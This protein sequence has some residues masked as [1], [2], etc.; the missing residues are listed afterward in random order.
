MINR[1]RPTFEFENGRYRC[2]PSFFTICFVALHR[3]FSLPL[4]LSTLLKIGFRRFGEPQLSGVPLANKQL[5]E[6]LQG[7]AGIGIAATTH[8]VMLFST[9]VLLRGL[10]FVV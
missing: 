5:P 3:Q 2:G 6:C 7:Q 9:S 1:N 4:R 10:R 8:S